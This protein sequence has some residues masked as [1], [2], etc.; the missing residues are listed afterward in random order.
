MKVLIATSLLCAIASL[1]VIIVFSTIPMVSGPGAEIIPLQIELFA[2]VCGVAW[3]VTAFWV[4][5]RQR[6]ITKTL[7]PQWLIR[8]LISVSV[9]Y[10]LGVFSLIIG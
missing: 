1:L 5:G 3:L 8:L 7:P 9:V 2:G 6:S 4:R 10:L